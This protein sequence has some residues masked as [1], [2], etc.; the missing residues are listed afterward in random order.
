MWAAINFQPLRCRRPTILARSISNASPNRARVPRY[1]A[2]LRRMEQIDLR[3]EA[4][5]KRISS[6]V[7]LLGAGVIAWHWQEL[8]HFSIATVRT[9]R[10]GIA[11]VISVL[12]YRRTYSKTYET[13]SDRL[14]AISE[15]HTRA[16]GY[17]L[18]ALLA[19]GGVFIKLVGIESFCPKYGANVCLYFLRDS[20]WPLPSSFL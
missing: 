18:K 8:R 13:E 17:T 5:P 20:T 15:C 6:L 12:D 2:I 14:Q 3:R 11:A 19:N 9:A 10:I 4:T 1:G 7:V 16:A